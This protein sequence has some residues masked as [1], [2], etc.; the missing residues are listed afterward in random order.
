MIRFFKQLGG[1]HRGN[2]GGYTDGFL[3]VM[4]FDTIV[5][6]NHVLAGFSQEIAALC[7]APVLSIFSSFETFMTLQYFQR[8]QCMDDVILP[9]LQTISLG[10][11]GNLESSEA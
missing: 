2:W 9:L 3:T 8:H 10:V 6:I 4:K 7:R 1:Q 5:T 11:Q